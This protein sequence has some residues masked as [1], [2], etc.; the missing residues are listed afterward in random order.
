[1]REGLEGRG[2]PVVCLYEDEAGRGTQGL[3]VRLLLDG[4]LVTWLLGDEGAR[5]SIDV[6]MAW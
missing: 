4:L 5:L 1:V 3:V 2:L 6:W